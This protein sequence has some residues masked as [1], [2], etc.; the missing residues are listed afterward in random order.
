MGLD[1]AAIRNRLMT[2]IAKKGVSD[3]EVSHSV[4]KSK[5]YISNIL[6]GRNNPS[7]KGL[8]DLCEYFGI[9]AQEFFDYDNENPAADRAVVDELKRLLGHHYEDLPEVLKNLTPDNVREIM[10]AYRAINTSLGRKGM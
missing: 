9:T 6:S 8:Y 1:Q 10:N 2:L 3:Q 5:A 7:I 4:G